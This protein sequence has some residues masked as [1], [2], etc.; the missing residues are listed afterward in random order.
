MIMMFVV[1]VVVTTYGRLWSHR[2]IKYGSPRGTGKQGF[3]RIN[4]QSIDHDENTSMRTPN[5]T[6][7]R[8]ALLYH[9]VLSAA[10]SQALV[11]HK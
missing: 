11:A 8:S 4:H 7:D 10:S 5:A 9:M 3:Y 6:N 1:V 2:C